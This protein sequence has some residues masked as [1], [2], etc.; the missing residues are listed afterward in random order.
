MTSID[1]KVIEKDIQETVSCLKK[2]TR[3]GVN[4][5]KDWYNLGKLFGKLEV[6]KKLGLL[7]KE[8]IIIYE[9]LEKF[10]F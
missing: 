4:S 10:L 7:K 6:A 5:E 1:E 9:T 8:D 3:K 2:V